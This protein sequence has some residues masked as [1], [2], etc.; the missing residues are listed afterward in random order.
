M[1]QIQ[2]LNLVNRTNFGGNPPG[3]PVTAI[4]DAAFAN[5]LHQKIDELID[6]F[7]PAGGLNGKILA[8]ASDADY[9]FAWVDQAAGSG[10]GGILSGASAPGAGIGVDGNFYI[11]TSTW[12]IYGPKAAGVWPAGVQLVGDDGISVLTGAGAP[13][14]ADGVDGQVYI[15]TTAWVGYKKVAG[16]WSAGQPYFPPLQ[17]SWMDSTDDAAILSTLYAT[18]E[19]NWVNGSTIVTGW[20]ELRL[21][22]DAN[23]LYLGYTDDI[24]IRV[25]LA[26]PAAGSSFDPNEVFTRRILAS[27]ASITTTTG[28]AGDEFVTGGVDEIGGMTL[29]FAN[30]DPATGVGFRKVANYW[31]MLSGG[32]SVEVKHTLHSSNATTDK[33]AAPFTGPWMVAV[34]FEYAGIIGDQM[35]KL[36]AGGN[37][38]FKIESN[39]SKANIRIDSTYRDIDAVAAD[40]NSLAV[41]F[42]NNFV[43]GQKYLVVAARTADG[44]NFA[45]LGTISVGATP[46]K[47]LELRSGSKNQTTLVHFI[48]KME[49]LD[50]AE[51]VYE[52]HNGTKVYEMNYLAGAFS[53]A[54]VIDM[55]K[56]AVSQYAV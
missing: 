6:K 24:V 41:A 55:F 37:K 45:A 42:K 16:S 43:V 39:A 28:L 52:F 4:I 49:N 44:K 2:K 15:D 13:N 34:V 5:A 17:Q 23:Y 12:T 19:F 35:A 38:G 29:T 32:G 56:Y 31:E 14:N 11:D 47:D 27:G 1:A 36:S 20:G 53:E 48:D 51:I 3:V 9:A 50:P 22:A 40:V 21:H 33:A 25:P 26:A 46:G 8:K 54:T 7:I 18:P 30:Q 10:G